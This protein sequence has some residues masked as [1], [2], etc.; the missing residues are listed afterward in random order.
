[1]RDDEHRVARGVPEAV[2][3][4]A[5]GQPELERVARHVNGLEGHDALARVQRLHD[6]L[7]LH[8]HELDALVALGGDERL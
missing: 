2:V 7:H 3:A 8:Q 1:V 6:D 4:H 5:K